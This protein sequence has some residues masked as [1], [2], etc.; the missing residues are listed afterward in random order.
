[1]HIRRLRK[2]RR[3]DQ[4]GTSWSKRNNMTLS[5]LNSFATCHL[6]R[7]TLRQC[8]L[9]CPQ[10]ANPQVRNVE[11]HPVAIS[12]SLCSLTITGSI[13]EASA[14][15]SWFCL[16]CPPRKMVYLPWSSHAQFNVNPF[17]LFTWKLMNVAGFCSLSLVFVFP[18]RV[19]S[20]LAITSF[21]PVNT[22]Y[23]YCLEP[24]Q[25]GGLTS[26]SL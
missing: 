26:P 16:F 3:D 22:V 2:C 25:R 7:P 14:H 6:I 8:H 1:M 18:V 10:G 20:V 19:K 24:S 21:I 5:P 9:H 4:L 17:S 13:C 11:S 15:S 12:F 23:N